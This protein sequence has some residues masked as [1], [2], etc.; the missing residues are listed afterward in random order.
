MTQGKE[1]V[2]FKSSDLIEKYKGRPSMRSVGLYRD[3]VEELG[4]DILGS[5]ICSP[6]LALTGAQEIFVE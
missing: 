6:S 1:T 3:I 5:S 2:E 4:Q